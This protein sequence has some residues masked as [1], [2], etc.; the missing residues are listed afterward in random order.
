MK[1]VFRALVCLLALHYGS[2]STFA[3]DTSTTSTATDLSTQP[4]PAIV[5]ETIPG[6][7]IQLGDFVVGP[8][9]VEV[10]VR[11]GETVYK[12]I[13]VTNRIDDN[14][15]FEFYVEDMS[16]SADGAE[17][18]VLLGDQDGPYSLKDYVSVPEKVITLKLG[19]RAR[20]PVAITMPQNAEPG[21][22]YGAVLVST[23][24]RDGASGETVASSPVVARIGTLFFITVPGESVT[25]GS[26]T[27]FRTLSNHWWFSKGPIP[28]GVTYENSGSVHQN[29][30][31]EIRV[32]NFFG[33]EVG[34]VE[35]DPWFVLPKSMRTREVTWDSEML[36]GRYRLTVNLNRGYDNIIDTKSYVVWVVP[37]QLILGVFTALF[38]IIFVIRLFFSKFELKR[39]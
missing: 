37:W 19:E 39:K 35:L 23:V 32:T 26:L 4:V 22:Y 25:G 30:Y 1:Y 33:Q 34:Y 10:T 29:P 5:T 21:G 20:V 27:S 7:D 16:G 17:A 31:G 36:L 15:S 13:T 18:A 6:T 12:E 14:R 2:L 8:G 28:L 9:K 3:Q 38:A 11:P 24:R